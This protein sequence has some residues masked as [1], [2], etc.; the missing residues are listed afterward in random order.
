MLARV[1]N[2]EAFR[3]YRESEDMTTDDLVRWL[4]PAIL[5]TRM[6]AAG[7]LP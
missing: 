6:L 7:R 1:S 3:R 5:A 4:P 2:I